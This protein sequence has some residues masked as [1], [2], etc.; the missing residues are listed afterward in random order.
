MAQWTIFRTTED[1][2]VVV[3]LDHADIVRMSETGDRLELVMSSGATLNVKCEA[4]IFTLFNAAMDL[5]PRYTG[6]V[7]SV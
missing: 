6:P 1:R 7:A 5:R 4:N 3:N 2:D